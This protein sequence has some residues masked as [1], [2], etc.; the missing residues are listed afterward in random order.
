MFL[1]NAVENSNDWIKKLEK[2]QRVRLC[3]RDLT[4]IIQENKGYHDGNL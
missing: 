3:T 1:F 4:N 2:C